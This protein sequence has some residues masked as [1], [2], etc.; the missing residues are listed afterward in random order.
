LAKFY[1]NGD[2]LIAAIGRS[3]VINIAEFKSTV[4][5]NHQIQVE[6]QEDTIESQLG[7]QLV[8][9]QILQYVGTNLERDDIGKLINA[10]PFG[11]WQDAFGDFTINEKNV[12]NDFLA[13]E[14]GEMPN[15]STSDDSA[16]CLKQVAKRKKERDFMLLAPEV[17]SLY[18]QYEDYHAQKQ[19]DEAAAL[20]AAQDE[21]IPTGGA[22]VACD[23][24]VPDQDPTKT[25]KRVRIPYQALDWLVKHLET[26]GMTMQTMEQMN[27]AQMSEV[28]GLLLGQGAQ[29]GQTNPQGVM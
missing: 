9:N 1:L 4:P 5:L 7:K 8:L 10:M 11:N 21:F 22:M 23:M 3:E 20:K 29:Q 25:P 24:Y 16:Y 6:E 18:Q 27:Q 26:Q 19:A 14:R 17:Q 15:I 12:K 28:A 13:I 2:E